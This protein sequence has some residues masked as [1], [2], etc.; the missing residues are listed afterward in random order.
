MSRVTITAA[1]AWLLAILLLWFMIRIDGSNPSWLQIETSKRSAAA[2]A[3]PNVL[4]DANRITLSCDDT[5]KHLRERLDTAR[6]CT[7]DSD[8]TLFDFGYPIDCM[9][10]VAKSEITDLRI[11]YRNYEES[12]EYRVYFDCP[13][14]PMRRRAVCRENRCTVALE[15]NDALE[16]E[17]LD[18]LGIGTSGPH[19]DR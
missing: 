9:T 17:T 18:Y 8:C 2:T 3:K 1:V 19:N 10:S 14:E 11:E 7:A 15:A 6:N 12:C 5:E 13:S 16:E 4:P